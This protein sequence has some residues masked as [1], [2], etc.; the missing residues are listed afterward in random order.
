MLKDTVLIMLLL[1]CTYTDLSKRLIYN[2]VLLPAAVF[3]LV[4]ALLTAGA[5]GLNQSISGLMLGFCLLLLPFWMGGLGAG[6]VKMLAAIGALQGP[7]FT[8]RAFLLSALVGGMWAFV[9]LVR[10]GRLLYTLN[11]LT[12]KACCFFR[13]MS[14]RGSSASLDELSLAE[15]LPYGAVL[16]LGTFLTYLSG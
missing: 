5:G 2:R 10:K 7:Y 13:G 16:A 14:V 12:L 15:T 8:W 4:Y 6:D 9:Y 3:G 1:V 11:T